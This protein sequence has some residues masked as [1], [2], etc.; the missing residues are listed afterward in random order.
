[1]GRNIAIYGG[2][3][4]PPHF[5]HLN[6]ASSFLAKMQ[7]DMLYIIPANIPPHKSLEQNLPAATR[8][9]MTRLAFENLP[10]Y[11]RNLTVSDYELLQG[12]TS[13]TILTIE[14]F[15]Q[16]VDKISLLC[17]TDMFLSLD[18]WH[19]AGEIFANAEIVCIRRENE[20]NF[21]KAIE[22]KSKFYRENFDAKIRFID[23]KPVIISSNQLRQM[24]AA[25]EDCSKFI[26]KNVLKY[27][28]EYKIYTSI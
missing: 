17:G 12:G 13:Y 8:L 2:T 24:L 19:R 23:T 5:G 25:K 14:H 11:G 6:V 9:E 1:M 21:T 16:N 22:E 15:M 18:S 4:S 3:F 7:P 10:E 26:P 27:I 28:N 20:K